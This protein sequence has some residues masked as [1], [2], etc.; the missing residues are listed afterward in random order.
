[1]LA[2]D[3]G[4]KRLSELLATANAPTAEA[5]EADR[6]A[7]VLGRLMDHEGLGGAYKVMLQV[8]E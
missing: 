3:G 5:L 2:A 6:E 8:R 4:E 7:G 1:L